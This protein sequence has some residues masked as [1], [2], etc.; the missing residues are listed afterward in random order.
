MTMLFGS[1]VATAL[2]AQLPGVTI[3]G[4]VVDEQG[5]PVAGARVVGYRCPVAGSSAA[6]IRSRSRRRQM[7]TGNSVSSL[8]QLGRATDEVSRLGLSSGLGDRGR[9][10]PTS[11]AI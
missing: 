2:V 11:T 5:K 9:A 10:R 8:R 6:A 4:K 1:I 3:Q 7:R